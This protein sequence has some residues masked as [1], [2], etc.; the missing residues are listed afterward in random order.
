MTEELQPKKQPFQLDLSYFIVAMFAVLF[1][2][3]LWV[4]Q[5]HTKTIPYSVFRA[6]LD[7]GEVTDLVI[8][9]ARIVG[10]YTKSSDAGKQHFSD[11]GVEPQL[12]DSAQ[13]LLARE[14]LGA[15][16]LAKLTTGLQQHRAARRELAAVQ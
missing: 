10:A 6:L 16:A 4:G 9:R 7:E 8:G 14:T 12:A 13:E 11:V 2:R 1:I 15:D 3:D 5:D